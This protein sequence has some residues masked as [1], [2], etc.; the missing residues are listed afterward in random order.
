MAAAI[1]P[2]LAFGAVNFAQPFL[3][4]RILNSINEPLGESQQDIVGGLIGATILIFVGIAVCPNSLFFSSFFPP[5]FPFG[6]VPS[7][8]H[9]RDVI[10]TSGIL[11]HIKHQFLGY[12]VHLSAS[13]IPTYYHGSWRT[14]LRDLPKDTGTQFGFCQGFSTC[15]T[16]VHR[17]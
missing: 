13:H 5:H 2:R 6:S 7:S 16:H 10:Q 9:F 11:A 4:N 3:I 8:P 15:D 14:Y 17:H 1:V 12:K